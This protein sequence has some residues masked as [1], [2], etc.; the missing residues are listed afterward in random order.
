M[1]ERHAAPARPHGRSGRRAMTLLLVGA[2]GRTGRHILAALRER[3]DCPPI[4]GVARRPFDLAGVE[5]F[6]GDM[7]NPVHRH[8][9][10]SGIETVI[11]YGP[12]FDP[13]EQAIGTGMIDA[14]ARCGVRRFV[15]L[16][17]IHPQID[18]LMNHASKLGVEAHLLDSDLA[19]TIVRPQHYM[20]NVDIG[21]VLAAGTLAMPFP[22]ATR[23]GHVDMADVATVVAKVACESGHDFAAYDCAADQHLSV[24]ELAE[25]IAGVAGRPIAAADM[26]V[27]AIVA[28]LTAGFDAASAPYATEAV[29]RLMGYYARRGIRGNANVLGWL[30]GRTPTS[31]ADY[32]A[33]S[34]RQSA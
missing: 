24:A 22:V 16:S 10:L 7:D 12:A 29:Y 2:T 4:R 17:V 34:I 23:L 26:P 3:P 31:F 27:D 1:G 8:A 19:W 14:A 25:I 28:H 5:A 13:R 9:A 33:R 21:R 32:V 11:H 15:Y 6:V 20:Q 18:D 30:L